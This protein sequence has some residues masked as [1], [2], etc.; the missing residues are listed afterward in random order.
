VLSLLPF[1]TV[2]RTTKST[3]A[4]AGEAVV[5]QIVSNLWKQAKSLL[6]ASEKK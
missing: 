6:F 3:K 1:K 4:K 2:F 5:P